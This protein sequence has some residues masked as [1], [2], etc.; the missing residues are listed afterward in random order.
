M[1]NNFKITTTS[2]KLSPTGKPINA[3]KAGATNTSRLYLAIDVGD[4]DKKDES[5][6]EE[7]KESTVTQSSARKKSSSIAPLSAC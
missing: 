5:I 2:N 4:K 1:N 3:S 7:Q 6:V